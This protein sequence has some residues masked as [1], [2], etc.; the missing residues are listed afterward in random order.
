MKK[1]TVGFSRG[2][3]IISD[4][5]CVLDDSPFSH[6]YFSFYSESLDRHI[7]YHANFMG[8]N[9]VNKER[10]EMSSD[11]LEEITLEIDE[12][13]YIRVMQFCID[14]SS[15]RYDIKGVIGKGLLRLGIMKSNP[16]NDGLKSVDCSEIVNA[17]LKCKGIEAGFNPATDSPKQ[18][19]EFLI[20]LQD[21]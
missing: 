21:R 13:I 20:S 8:V 16:W 1:V 9:F 5:I 12:E 18:I 6:T 11:I 14:K 10:F 4:I 7:I 19:Y 2:R 15:I 3:T 17:I